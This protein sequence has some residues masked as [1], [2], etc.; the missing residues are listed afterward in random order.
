MIVD[1]ANNVDPG[2]NRNKTIG[3]FKNVEVRSRAAA[4]DEMAE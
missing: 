2:E 3:A 4:W 1:E